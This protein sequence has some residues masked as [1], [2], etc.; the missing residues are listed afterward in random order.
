MSEVMGIRPW[1][2]DLMTV[3]QMD[4]A[5]AYVEETIRKMKEAQQ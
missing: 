4:D 3:E 1:E 5:L 2:H